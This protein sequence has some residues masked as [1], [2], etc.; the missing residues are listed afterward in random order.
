MTIPRVYKT[1]VWGPAGTPF[2]GIEMGYPPVKGCF[3]CGNN[4]L[5]AFEPWVMDT[6]TAEG[7]VMPAS[8]PGTV[9]ARGDEQPTFHLIPEP[10]TVIAVPYYHLTRPRVGRVRW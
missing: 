8:F 10:F 2:Y 6:N 7:F 9:K 4:A 1:E 3:L 5:L